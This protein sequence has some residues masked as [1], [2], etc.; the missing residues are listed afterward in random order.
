MT[1]LTQP[2]IYSAEELAEIIAEFQQMPFYDKILTRKELEDM[3][4]IT[5]Q[6]RKSRSAYI[7]NLVKEG[8]LIP[9]LNPLTNKPATEHKFTLLQIQAYLARLV[10]A[11]NTAAEKQNKLLN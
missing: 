7:Q 4:G 9:L 6:V 2:K 10:D 11:S 3:L 8:V 1:E 5:D